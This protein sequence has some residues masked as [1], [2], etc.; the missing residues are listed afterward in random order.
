MSNQHYNQPTFVTHDGSG[1]HSHMHQNNQQNM[2]GQMSGISVQ[3]MLGNNNN[4]G[5]PMQMQHVQ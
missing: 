3:N 2:Q 5:T 1:K 4:N